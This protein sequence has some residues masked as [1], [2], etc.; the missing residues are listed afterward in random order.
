VSAL[1]DA[2]RLDRPAPAA[3]LRTSLALAAL[4]A[5]LVH[6]MSLT[7]GGGPSRLATGLLLVAVAAVLAF[8]RSRAVLAP[9]AALSATLTL[10]WTATRI[11]GLP[12][13]LDGILAALVQLVLAGGALALLR[14]GA[15][16]RWSRLAFA[17][18]ALAAL[19]VFGHFGH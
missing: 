15:Y 12:V 3:E 17:V 4:G 16:S 18:F 6:A 10:G 7:H 19:S 1:T 8:T 14:G 11:S 2:G 13:G 5:A 9:A